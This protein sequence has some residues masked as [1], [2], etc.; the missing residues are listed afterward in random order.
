[1]EISELAQ[2]EDLTNNTNLYNTNK[3]FK[4]DKTP[5]SLLGKSIFKTIL[6]SS[7]SKLTYESIIEDCTKRNILFLDLSFPANYYSISKGMIKDDINSIHHR[8]WSNIKWWE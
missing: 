3:K 5:L 6:N 1:M 2:S 4:L 8:I 7:S